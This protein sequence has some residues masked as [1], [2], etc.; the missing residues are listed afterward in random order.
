MIRFPTLSY[1]RSNSLISQKSESESTDIAVTETITAATVTSHE[2]KIASYEYPP[3][4]TFSNPFGQEKIATDFYLKTL[5]GWAEKGTQEEHRATAMM[6][7][8]AWLADK[9]RQRNSM[10]RLN[11]LG[12]KA[13]PPLPDQ[14]Q[15]LDAS[16]NQLNHLSSIALPRH[17]IY[18]SISNNC[19]SRLPRL[20]AKLKHLFVDNN[21]LTGLPID[22]PKGL[23]CLN[24]AENKIALLHSLPDTLSYLNVNDN[25]LVCLPKLPT[26]LVHLFVDNNFIH[27]LPDHLPTTLN[28]VSF[29]GNRLRQLPAALFNLPYSCRIY[30]EG[31]PLSHPAR[32]NLQAQMH[33]RGYQ[34]PLIYFSP[35]IITDIV[36]AR[37][38]AEA[39]SDWYE[40]PQQA[41]AQKIWQ[42]WQS[43]QHAD[44][45][46]LFLDKLSATLSGRSSAFLH[47]VRTWLDQLSIDD[48]LRTHVFQVA[49]D[50]LGSCEDRVVLTLNTMKKESINLDV[51]RGRYDD[52][53]DTLI[54]IA[55]Q[56]FRLDQLEKIAYNKVKSL[57]SKIN[58]IGGNE[59]AID[60]IEVYLGYQVNLRE[61]LQLPLDIS[62]MFFSSD[63]TPA[64]FDAAAKQIIED[65]KT[66][67]LHYLSTEWSPWQSVLQRLYPTEYAQAQEKISM[68]A[69]TEFSHRQSIYL[70]EHNLEDNEI[71]RALSAQ[72]ILDDI[73]YEIHGTLTKKLAEQ[74]G[75]NLDKL[76]IDLSS[77]Q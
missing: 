75:L 51:Q 12:L 3:F 27:R 49:R 38:L 35:P 73:A 67:F 9:P 17:L 42:A 66:N 44:D 5:R 18:L 6:N 76:K 30:I 71:N 47:Q 46:S 62:A 65:E 52:Q 24:A 64:E 4:V 77:N 1:V 34:G 40:K 13:L 58:A 14:L 32:Q 21:A 7:I 72:T 56:M 55:R 53:L 63:V 33:A 74:H 54:T 2:K 60:E 41:T 43:Q 57:E 28:H 19:L 59:N 45:F 48:D 69:D 8:E 29:F 22:L 50:A 70:R 39:A 68:C 23:L 16:D 36:T 31:N 37:P 10:L 15:L 11:G 26:S 25:Q 20:P 61:T